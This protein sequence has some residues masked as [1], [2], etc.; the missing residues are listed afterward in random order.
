VSEEVRPSAD[1]RTLWV[2]PD[3]STRPHPPPMRGPFVPLLLAALAM[4][5]WLGAQA[6]QLARERQQLESAKT[7]LA[8]QEETATKVR[9]S[10]DQVATATAKLAADGNANARA[11]VEQL[12]SRGITINPSSGAS[13]PR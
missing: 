4:T 7:S 3:A 8:M 11:I 9:A 1:A 6:L 13:A 5:T 2:E 12:R 10:L